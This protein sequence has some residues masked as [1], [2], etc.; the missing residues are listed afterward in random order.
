MLFIGK[1]LVLTTDLHR[2]VA[3]GSDARDTCPLKRSILMHDCLDITV[4]VNLGHTTV[5]LQ[6]VGG[7]V[8]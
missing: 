7:I 5:C 1:L 3:M 6:Y 4:H 8:L 2:S